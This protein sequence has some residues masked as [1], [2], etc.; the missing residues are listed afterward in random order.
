MIYLTF[1]K[2]HIYDILYPVLRSVLTNTITGLVYL[3]HCPISALVNTEIS[4]K[5]IFLNNRST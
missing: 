2:Y 5:K 1:E 3:T 4:R